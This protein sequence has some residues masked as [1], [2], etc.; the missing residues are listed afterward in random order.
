V[1]MRRL[2]RAGPEISALG[3]GTWALAGRYRFGWG[4]VDDDESV[5]T[6]RRAVEA[7]VSWVDTAP[8]YG[9]GHSEEVVGRALEPFRFDQMRPGC[10]DPH[11]RVQD[12]DLG[13]IWAA[14]NFPSMV[15]GF[16]GRVFF[17][18]QDPELGAAC[19]RAWN[20]WFHEE[21]Y[22]PHP[23]RFIPLGIAMLSDPEA[24]VAH[25]TTAHYLTWRDTVAPLMAEPRVGVVYAEVSADARGW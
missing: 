17:N 6:I 11:A 12:M 24:A 19:I 7:G 22:T 13:G 8:T 9:D 25:K 1:V 18:A 20:D 15:S 4:A 2:G 10:Y 5:A 21:W 23:T 3:F 14:V 16:C